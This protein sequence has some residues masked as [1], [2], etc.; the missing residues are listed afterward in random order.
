MKVSAKVYSEYRDERRGRLIRE[1]A[2]RTIAGSRGPQ[3]QSA[4]PELIRHAGGEAQREGTAMAHS[5]KHNPHRE[6]EE[7]TAGAGSGSAPLEPAS[8][9]PRAG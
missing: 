5:S 6:M 7:R 3:K 4:T 2:V 1:E 8:T 9:L